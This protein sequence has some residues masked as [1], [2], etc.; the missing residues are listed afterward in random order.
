MLDKINIKL[1]KYNEVLNK[2]KGIE[3]M[4]NINNKIKEIENVVASKYDCKEFPPFGP[5]N[6]KS[7]WICCPIRT[8]FAGPFVN[9]NKLILQCIKEARMNKEK[10]NMIGSKNKNVHIMA[11]CCNPGA[12]I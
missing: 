3:S 2:Y 4:E 7:K 11:L 9:V 8:E 5:V 10:Y 12:I 1:D 6:E